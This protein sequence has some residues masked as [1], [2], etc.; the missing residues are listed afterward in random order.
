[1]KTIPEK[2]RAIMT[3]TGWKQMQLAEK[4]EV[5]QSTVNRWLAGAEPEGHRR[6]AINE[7]YER[8]TDES[9]SSGDNWHPIP[10]VGFIGAGAEI[11]PEFEQV[12]PE[13]LDQVHVPFALPEEMIALEVRGD[14]ML[15]VYKDGHVVVVYK[16]QKK[17][18]QAFFGEDAAVRTSD[19][20]RFLKT[21]MKG[22]PVTLMSFN[23]APIENV[24]LEWVGE[25]FAVLPRTQLKRVDRIGGIQG[26]LKLG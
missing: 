11:M 25:I 9:P 7:A 26:S 5:S 21:I 22:S 23:A 12:P 10:I 2:I 14:S 1:M 18:I 16:E 19:G 4:F 6:D 15:P 17:P 13:G 24:G 3:S 8:L 20:R